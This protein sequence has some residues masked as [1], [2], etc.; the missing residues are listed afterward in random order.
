MDEIV[1]AGDGV[2]TDVYLTDSFYGPAHLMLD[3]GITLGCGGTS[4]CPNDAVNR[5]TVAAFLIRSLYVSLGGNPFPCDPVTNPTGFTF[6]TTPYFTD[7]P[8][9]HT[10]FGYVQKMKDL[11]ITS[12]CTATTYCPNDS[13]SNI[14]IAVFTIRA[15]ELRTSS[16][17]PGQPGP[18]IPRSMGTFYYVRGV[19]GD[20]MY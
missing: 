12:G 17:V 4:F 8:S 14:Q 10:F 13:I 1:H 2:Q 11:G 16:T 5:G 9:T 7:V 3:R 20:Y 6:T 15:W 19:L 18:A